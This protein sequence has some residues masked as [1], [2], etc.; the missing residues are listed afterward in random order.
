MP[1]I[2]L[3][4]NTDSET[5]INIDKI[6]AVLTMNFSSGNGVFASDA[7]FFTWINKTRHVD[8]EINKFILSLPSTEGH[9]D[10]VGELIANCNNYIKLTRDID[11]KETA[12]L[13][14][15][16]LGAIEKDINALTGEDGGV[17][18]AKAVEG[19]NRA[20]N[21]KYINTNEMK[22]IQLMIK[23]VD[24]VA[25]ELEKLAINEYNAKI[26]ERTNEFDG[27]VKSSD[28][29]NTQKNELQT[30]IDADCPGLTTDKFEE[31]ISLLKAREERLTQ[32]VAADNKS[33]EQ[34]NNA[35]AAEER[36]LSDNRKKLE[37]LRES[38]ATAENSIE[39]AAKQ[40]E[41]ETL[42]MNLKQAQANVLA[43]D[44]SE[45]INIIKHNQWLIAEETKIINAQIPE[46]IREVFFDKLNDHTKCG[47]LAAQAQALGS[48]SKAEALSAFNENGNDLA[49][50]FIALYD[51]AYPEAK[52][53]AVGKF[54]G[55]Q[56]SGK[57]VLANLV[58][59]FYKKNASGNF[60]EALAAEFKK[61]QTKLEN[62]V[63]AFKQKNITI[64][65]YNS[66]IKRI[67]NSHQPND[68]S[69]VTENTALKEKLEAAKQTNEGMLNY[70]DKALP[71]VIKTRDTL[72][73]DIK[74][75]ENSIAENQKSLAEK[76][77]ARKEQTDR[78]NA[79][80]RQLNECERNIS[81]LDRLNNK[82]KALEQKRTGLENTARAFCADKEELPL[83]RDRRPDRIN[84]RLDGF[85]SRLTENQTRLHRNSDEYNKLSEALANARNQGAGKLRE[86]LVKLEDAAI[87]YINA[88]GTAGIT[89][90]SLMG[91]TRLSLAREIQGFCDGLE[92]PMVSQPIDYSDAKTAEAGMR[93]LVAQNRIEMMFPKM[94]AARAAAVNANLNI[95]IDAPN[96]Q[97][98]ENAH[99]TPQLN[100]PVRE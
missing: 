41:Q 70:I 55:M 27:I 59:S 43:A 56:P 65:A 54:F 38:L 92:A 51:K 63:K 30:E 91:E 25:A 68:F 78:L 19:F 21:Y 84:R 6:S 87:R 8:D 7:Q 74:A 36:T 11:L 58:N 89:G 95:N 66:T 69:G 79:D 62:D 33:L 64:G 34:L 83:L 60:G 49:G 3:P 32:Q 40:R 73:K 47:E 97:Q 67:R 94:P 81:A 18:F 26:T 20:T 31:S 1:G 10:E 71:G 72:L 52:K 98:P 93:R 4:K 44:N 13:T 76:N 2:M 82:A 29:Y 46:N 57:E 96:L 48:I 5:R 23:R 80:T 24:K 45:Q 75:T 61:I 37:G 86:N 12:S 35:I 85:I 99:D 14:D 16:R 28:S 9:T 39:R 77:T 53:S 100:A 88:K 22:A 17:G 15:E 50:N 90:R 42:E